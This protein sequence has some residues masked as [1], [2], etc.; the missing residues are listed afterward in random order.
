MLFDDPIAAIG[1]FRDL[2]GSIFQGRLLHILPAAVKRENKLDDFAVS[3][4]PLKKQKLLHKRAEAST[5]TFNWNSLF[6]NTDAVITSV[7]ERLGIA[8][9]ELIDPTSSDAAVKQAQAETHVIQETKSYFEGHG[10]DLNAFSKRARGD[11]ALLVKNF[12]YGTSTEELK[13]LFTQYGSIQKVL[14]PPS[15]TI[16]IIQFDAAPDARKAFGS[17][18]YRKFK[19]S[20]LFLEKA[21]KDLFK[22][23]GQRGELPTQTPTGQDQL[24]TVQQVEPVDEEGTSTS[25]IFV[26]NLNFST[27]QIRFYETF[28]PL[29]GLVSARVKTKSDPKRPGEVLSMGFGFLEFRTSD[30]AT[31]ALK[32]MNGYE[33]DGHQ[34]LLKA[35]HKGNDAAQERRTADNERK[36]KNRKS[37]IIIK[38]LPFEASKKDV[39]DLFKSYGQLRAVRVPKKFDSSRKGFAFAEFTTPREAESAIEALRNTHLLGRRLVLD[40]AAGE[41][42]DPEKEIEKMQRKVGNQSD[43]MALRKLTQ[44]SERKKFVADEED[45]GGE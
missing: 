45:D 31:A 19:D 7:S 32:A 23:E 29:D 44:S 9:S 12:P 14:V 34:L 40:F 17:L 11:T 37:K 43:N 41:T 33:L 18:A 39:R 16:G 38:N 22:E 3:Q 42:E 4:L 27:T 30:Q 15:G 26:K 8:K 5:S 2:D 13:T 25:T 28:Q 10:I 35:S 1:A 20:V 36:K 24:A 6:M 21:P